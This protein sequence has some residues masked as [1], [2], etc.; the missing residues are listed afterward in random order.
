[1]TKPTPVSPSVTFSL[2]WTHFATLT[3]HVLEAFSGSGLCL[4][5]GEAGLRLSASTPVAEVT[6]PCPCDLLGKAE[7][8]SRKTGLTGAVH[9][10]NRGQR[11]RVQGSSMAQSEG[12]GLP[13]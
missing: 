1:M 13:A 10:R 11:G 3:L 12:P 9:W 2:V 4:R 8:D 5:Y 6:D 7:R